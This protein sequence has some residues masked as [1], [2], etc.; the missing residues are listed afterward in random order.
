MHPWPPSKK[1]WSRPR[2]AAN[3]LKGPTPPCHAHPHYL[4]KATISAA[5]CLANFSHALPT[6]HPAETARTAANAVSCREHMAAAVT[7]PPPAPPRWPLRAAAL[8]PGAAPRSPCTPASPPRCRSCRAPCRR[9]SPAAPVCLRS[10]GVPYL[11]QA[12]GKCGIASCFQTSTEL[13]AGT[14]QGSAFCMRA[15][16]STSM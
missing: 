7:G 13:H 15:A 16:H 8:T 2:W 14:K 9:R 1:P 4:R 12:V 10:A 6:T 3:Q 11:M 5:E